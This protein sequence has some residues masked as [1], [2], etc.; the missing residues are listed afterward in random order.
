[1]FCF[2]LA[3]DAWGHLFPIKPCDIRGFFVCH[4]KLIIYTK[5]IFSCLIGACNNFKYI[6]FKFIFCAY[7]CIC[8]DVC[9]PQPMKVRWIGCSQ[10]SSSPLLLP[11]GSWRLSSGYLKHF[12]DPAFFIWSVLW[13]KS[14]MFHAHGDIYWKTTM[15]FIV[16]YNFLSKKMGQKILYA[17]IL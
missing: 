6:I 5:K 10:F 7:V 14:I 16:F 13:S 2:Y 12:P 15:F 17:R 3:L 8:V 9:I 1:M 4:W 11:C